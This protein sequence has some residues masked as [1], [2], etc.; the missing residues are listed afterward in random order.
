MDQGHSERSLGRSCCGETQIKQCESA[1]E[2]MVNSA[3][4]KWRDEV[5]IAQSS[6]LPVTARTAQDETS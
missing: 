5:R 3:G 2:H 4:T 1:L 6:K